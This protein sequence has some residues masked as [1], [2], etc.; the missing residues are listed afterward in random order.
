M[1]VSGLLHIIQRLSVVT[2]YIMSP[3]VSIQVRLAALDFVMQKDWLT[4][5]LAFTSLSIISKL[6]Y[7]VCGQKDWL[8]GTL[9]VTSLSTISKLTCLVCGQK[10]WLIGALA[11]TSLSTNECSRFTCLASLRTTSLK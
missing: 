5:S 4:G 1:C 9:T 7:L 8:T 11:L 10:D 2:M 6:T 3:A